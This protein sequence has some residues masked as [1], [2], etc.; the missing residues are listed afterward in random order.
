MSLDEAEA[1]LAGIRV[2]EV[3]MYVQ[4]PVC[5]LALASLGADVIKIEQVGSA[6]YM[7]SF[8][9]AF[10]VTFDDRG[11]EWMYASL[12]RNKRA[13]TL[14]FTSEIGRPVFEKLIAEADVFITNLRASG[15]E[16]MGLDPDTL[17]AINPRLVYCRGGGFVLEGPLAE[18]PCQD[19]VGMAFGGFMDV[20]S[21]GEAPNYPPGS[22]SD[23][24][25]GTNMAS[26]ALAGLVKRSVTG[27]GCV[28]GTSQTQS[29]LWLELQG[30]GI[31]ANLGQRVE[32]FRHDQTSNPL[33]TVYETADGWIAIAALLPP[34]WPTLAGILEFDHLLDD[35]RFGDFWK[36]LD[37]R[38]DFRPMMAEK[39]R[40]NSTQHWWD[41]LRAADLWAAPVNA[42]TD[43]AD[44][45]HIRSNDYLV[46]FD[47]GFVG[48]PA[49]YFVDGH[50]GERGSAAEYNEHTDEILAELGHDESSILEL[51]A[52]GAIW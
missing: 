43:L 37:N 36:V 46:D 10:G 34:Q 28:V 23:I 18:A 38:D 27:K 6:D 50:R 29:L 11:K 25:T 14:D 2:V 5:G 45:E 32:P 4:G 51:R 22:M 48:P 8:Q 13:L 16:R 1:P 24:L 15:L 31:A 44:D 12:N 19:T 20:T 26:G 49:P 3:T 17:L 39:M 42:L 9:A 21:Q 33:F 7:R 35:P 30:V 52:S 47:D 41:L 40:T